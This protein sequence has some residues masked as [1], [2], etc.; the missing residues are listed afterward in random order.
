[1]NV[2]TDT[3]TAFGYCETQAS[4]FRFDEGDEELYLLKGENS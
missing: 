4:F 3:L 2:T 1:M